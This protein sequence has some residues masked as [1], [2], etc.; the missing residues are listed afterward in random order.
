MCLKT[1][2]IP[3][4]YTFYQFEYFITACLCLVEIYQEIFQ[5]NSFNENDLM[6]LFN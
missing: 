4:K 1:D 5:S 3:L 2:T 6:V